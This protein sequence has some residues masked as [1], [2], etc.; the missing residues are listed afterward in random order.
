[1]NMIILTE[2]QAKELKE[3]NAKF[4]HLNRAIQ[5]IPLSDG[6]HGVSDDILSDSGTWG[7]WIDFLSPLPQREVLGQELEVPDTLL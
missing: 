1:M 2:K 4:I 6:S 5:P 7:E 3:I